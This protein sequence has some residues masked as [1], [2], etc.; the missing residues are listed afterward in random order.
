MSLEQLPISLPKKLPKR[1]KPR[2][3]RMPSKKPEEEE[4]DEEDE[5]EG[6]PD[7]DE[8][9]T[10]KV[11]KA[12]KINDVLVK[13]E[14]SLGILDERCKAA[15]F[16]INAGNRERPE[17]C[18]AAKIPYS[19]LSNVLVKLEQKHLIKKAGYGK[20]EAVSK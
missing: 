5:V 4:E 7:E 18:K 19:S 1:L 9:L 16:A 11:V 12:S 13:A 20:F 6:E 15:L 2:K 14:E 8:A 10:A 3:P 17:I